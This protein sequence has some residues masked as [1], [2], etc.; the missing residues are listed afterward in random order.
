MLHG[1]AEGVRAA[2][3]A[4]SADVS[5][6][7]AEELVLVKDGAH[8]VGHDVMIMSAAVPAGT[9]SAKSSSPTM[10]LIWGMSLRAAISYGLGHLQQRL[11]NPVRPHP[12]IRLQQRCAAHKAQLLLGFI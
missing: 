6:H 5:V 11:A 7:S 3:G 8:S 2:I 4:K 12:A 1:Q 9:L 10:V